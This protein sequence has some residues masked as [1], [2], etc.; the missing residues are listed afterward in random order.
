M[1]EST[2]IVCES[3]HTFLRLPIFLKVN[4]VR[5]FIMRVNRTTL[6]RGVGSQSGSDGLS[7]PTNFDILVTDANKIKSAQL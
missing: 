2:L 4:L 1:C 3:T 7:F 5:E 6:Y